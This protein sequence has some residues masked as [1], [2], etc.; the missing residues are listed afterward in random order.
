MVY[1]ISL[2]VSFHPIMRDPG[3]FHG[4]F[5]NASL[6]YVDLIKK[7]NCGKNFRF[8]ISDL[9]V[10]FRYWISKPGVLVEPT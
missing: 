9:N 2:A 4:I 1:P 3:L 10:M 7:G 8:Q 5:W 6:G